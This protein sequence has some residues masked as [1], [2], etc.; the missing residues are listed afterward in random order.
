[1]I[2]ELQV[3]AR[4]VVLAG[5]AIQ[6][7]SLLLRNGMG[8]RHIGEHLHVHLATGCIATAPGDILGWRGI[9]QGFYSDEFLDSDQ[10][11]L[12]S[13]WATPEVFF[14]SFPFG[15]EG[16]QKMLDFRRVVGCGG[17][18]ADRSEGQVK[19]GTQPG[20]AKVHYNVGDEDKERLVRLAA[21]ISELLLAAGASDVMSGIYGVPALNSMDEVREHLRPEAVRTKQLMMIYSSH[22]QGTL[23]MG[24]DPKRSAVDCS[25]RLYGTE[26][27]YVMDASV[28]PDVLGVNPQIT[29][30]SLSLLL[31]QSLGEE[32]G[33]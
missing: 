13:F 9:P 25:G 32:L 30:M 22:P 1:V 16:L 33:R 23:R 15:H 4:A 26:G 24:T 31:A 12:E 29:V 5:G 27:L 2:G 11:I 8:N 28:F 18:I 6:S 17:T 10:M 21:R 14:Q 19:L 7:P 20:R 3:R